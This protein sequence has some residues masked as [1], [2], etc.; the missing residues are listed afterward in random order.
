VFYFFSRGAS[1]I[2]C[3]VRVDR[4]GAGYELVVDGPESLHVEHFN[5]T[6]ALNRRWCELQHSLV[7][8]GWSGP[9]AC[10]A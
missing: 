2:R 3:E 7:K 8:E 9:D 5:E 10:R 1:Q 4:T 6:N